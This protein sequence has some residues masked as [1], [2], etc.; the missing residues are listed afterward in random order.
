MS[1][2]VIDYSPLET[3]RLGGMLRQFDKHYRLLFGVRQRR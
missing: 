2:L 1:A 3:I